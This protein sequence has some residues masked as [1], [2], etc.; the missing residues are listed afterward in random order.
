MLP[1]NSEILMWRGY[2]ISIVSL[3]LAFYFL[4]IDE[5]YNFPNYAITPDISENLQYK[6]EEIGIMSS[7]FA[8][9][10]IKSSL[11]WKSINLIICSLNS[12]GELQTIHKSDNSGFG[13]GILHLL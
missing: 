7:K 6:I 3:S 1:W 13:S 9:L 11:N 12:F 8:D 5:K 10:L 4:F 2:K